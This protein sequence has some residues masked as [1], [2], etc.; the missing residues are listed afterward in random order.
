MRNYRSPAVPI[1]ADPMVQPWTEEKRLFKPCISAPMPT[2]DQ[3]GLYQQRQAG[4]RKKQPNGCK[5]L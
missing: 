5:N 1:L 3:V 4:K 2:L